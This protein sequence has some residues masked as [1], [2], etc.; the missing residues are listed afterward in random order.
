MSKGSEPGLYKR[1]RASGLASAS[2]SRLA[3][4]DT[5]KGLGILLV[6]LCHVHNEGVVNDWIYSFHMP[7]F[8][9]LSGYLFRAGDDPRDFLRRKV[10]SLLVPY[11]AFGIPLTIFDVLWCGGSLADVPWALLHL[12]LQKRMYT[13][14]FLAC[15]FVLEV[16]LFV[17]VYSFRCS[18]SQWILLCLVLP[19]G[20]WIYYLL[21][22][23]SLYWNI[24][25]VPMAFPFL[26]GGYFVRQWSARSGERWERM[27]VR[28]P[29]FWLAVGLA[30]NVCC[31]VL[32]VVL[33]GGGLEFFHCHYGVLPLTYASA[34]G[35]IL[36]VCMACQFLHSRVL[37]YVGRNSMLFFA[38]HQTFGLPV[39]RELMTA[40]GADPEGM[41]AACLPGSVLVQFVLVLVMMAG[42]NEVVKVLRGM[43]VRR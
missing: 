1:D 7:L 23:G 34:F 19:V 31:Y 32:N 28:G 8:F 27:R 10:R 24:D 12:C 15:L 26:C 17:L 42:C 25:V 6:I 40:V 16:L 3:W 21:G 30:V 18:M 36:M 41:T 2:G 35:G 11:F 4:V 43:L 22:G 13:L 39:V 5:A 14:W 38:W 9:F 29:V 37:T 20:G 33:V